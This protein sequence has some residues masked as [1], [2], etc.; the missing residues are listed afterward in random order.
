MRSAEN[1]LVV[2][3]GDADSPVAR[4]DVTE[5]AFPVPVIFE[6]GIS[7]PAA[8]VSDGNCPD[9]PARGGVKIIRDDFTIGDGCSSGF[10]VTRAGQ[11][12]ILTAGHCAFLNSRW[13]IAG[14]ALG[15]ALVVRNDSFADIAYLKLGSA[16]QLPF[17]SGVYRNTASPN[18]PMRGRNVI[19]TRAMQGA[20]LIT[21][22]HRLDEPQTG[23]VLNGDAAYTDP[24]NG[25][26]DQSLI[27]TNACVLRGDSG[28]VQYS[29][30]QIAWGI[31]QGTNSPDSCAGPLLLRS[32]YVYGWRAEQATNSVIFTQ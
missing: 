10:T 3:L 8:C 22:G 31:I 11:K 9:A 7:T 30:N 23:T 15:E 1:S 13:S 4:R 5:A 25:V 32:Y 2:G 14:T 16:Y 26:R 6:I 19:G 29:V 17:Q 24:N 20:P 12:G 18:Y 21:S 27:E 28:G